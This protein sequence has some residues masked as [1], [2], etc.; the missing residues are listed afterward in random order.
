MIF[1]SDFQ[2]TIEAT[3]HG[4]TNLNKPCIF[5]EI[6]TTEKQWSDVELCSAIALTIK[7][8]LQQPLQQFPSALCFG[9]THYSEKFTNEVINGK[10][11]LGTVIPK[12]ALEFLD[13][14]LFR[15][16]ME[17]NIGAEAAILDWNGLGKNK[18]KV[19]DLLSTTKL[20][21]IKV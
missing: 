9:G 6:G 20:D 10:F 19:V 14:V 3:H 11:A 4:P 13:E 7:E 12:H 1:F 21:L 8:I 5:I 16:I 17:R 2:I 18:Q 15:H